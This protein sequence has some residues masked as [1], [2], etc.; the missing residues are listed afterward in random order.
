MIAAG[1]I[2]AALLAEALAWSIAAAVVALAFDDGPG[3]VGPLSFV[4]V[5][6]TGYALP[7]L[8]AGRAAGPRATGAVTATA[9]VLI[10]ALASLE[11]TGSL[12]AFTFTWLADFYREPQ[13]TLR[14]GAP[15]LAAV[16]LLAGAWATG[17][18]RATRDGDL[19][20]HARSLVFPFAMVISL[21]VV[22]SGSASAGRFAPLVAAFFAAAVVS[23]AWAQLALSGTDAE[24]L[25]RGG[26]TAALVVGTALVASTGFIL[27]GLGWRVLGP[28]IAPAVATAVEAVLVVILTPVAW[29][30]TFVVERLAGGDPF[31]GLER[32]AETARTDRPSGGGEAPSAAERVGIFGLR[33]LA[34]IAFTSLVAGIVVL[35]TRVRQ[36]YRGS[37]EATASQR[38]A[39]GLLDDLRALLRAATPGARRPPSHLGASHAARLY[40]DVLRDA[41]RR[42]HPR[43]PSQTPHEFAPVLHETYATPVTDDIT[44]AFE[45]ARY[46]GREPDPARLAELERHWRSHR[47]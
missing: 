33:T 13:A 14:H 6:I 10:V 22:A 5:V 40:L 7:G 27:F 37:R 19:E 29:L 34:L 26:V 32:L 30:L 9:L 44:A 4:L 31:T 38:S 23:L 21:A 25:R 41:E 17:A 42:G 16:L 15:A 45:D 8:A 28:V 24:R 43:A 11:T 20:T 39:G 36:R 47:R 35:W 46:G 2:G 1:A 3:P 18:A 12:G